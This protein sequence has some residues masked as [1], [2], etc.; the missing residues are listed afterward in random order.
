MSKKVSIYIPTHNRVD[1]LERA[2]ESVKKQTYEDWEL[3]IVNDCSSDGTYEY[4]ESIKSNSIKVFHHA[5][6]KGACAARNL[7][8]QNATGHFVTGLDDDD[9]FENNRL[10]EFVNAWETKKEDVVFLF[11][12]QKEYN[13][14]DITV[15]RVIRF[16]YLNQKDLLIGNMVG[17]QVFTDKESFLKVGCFDENLTMWQDFDCWYRLLG[18]GSGQYVDNTSYIMDVNDTRTRITG[19]KKD[20][21]LSTLSYFSAKHSLGAVERSA[22]KLHLVYYGFYKNNFLF[23]I[24]KLYFSILMGNFKKIYLE[25]GTLK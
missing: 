21:V 7:A 23:K 8:I 22:L 6:S 14:G 18:L 25:R 12:G 13:N 16:R 10:E 4:L 2:V 3:L 1:L 20:E 19:K 11:T 24:R 5:V 15:S 17:N 9:Y